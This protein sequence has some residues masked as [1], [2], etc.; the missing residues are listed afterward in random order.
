MF[1]RHPITPEVLNT[2]VVSE[3]DCFVAEDPNVVM[4]TRIAEV[5][6]LQEKVIACIMNYN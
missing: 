6:A 1:H 5:T 4:E 2:K 3:T